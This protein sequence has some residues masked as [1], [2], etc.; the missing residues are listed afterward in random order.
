MRDVKKGSS[1]DEQG[2]KKY[3]H[4]FSINK[5]NVVGESHKVMEGLLRNSG[6]SVDFG[7]L[8]PK[9]FDASLRKFSYS[10]TFGYNY[11]FC[12]N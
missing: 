9:K 8:R 6:P 2:I 1:A 5:I 10:E 11:P 4:I 7:V 12:I 3:D